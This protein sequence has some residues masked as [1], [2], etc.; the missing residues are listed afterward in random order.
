MNIITIAALIVATA[1]LMIPVLIIW[2]INVKGTLEYL[3][4]KLPRV[5]LVNKSRT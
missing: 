5:S 4:G 3:K 1:I 2:Y